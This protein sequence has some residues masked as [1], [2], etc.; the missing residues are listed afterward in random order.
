MLKISKKEKN[1]NLYNFDLENK[2]QKKIK[3]KD[4]REAINP[5]NSNNEIII[6]VTKYPDDKK[7]KEKNKQDKRRK[8]ANSKIKINKREREDKI[9]LK[10]EQKKKINKKVENAD[11]I[12]DNPKKDYT[13]PKKVI[14]WTSICAI[15]IGI[16]VYGML[17]P[18]FNINIVTVKNNEKIPTET[19][20]NLANIKIGENI[21][22]INKKEIEKNIKNNGYIDKI[23]VKRKLPDEI[24][25][26]VKERKATYMV[27][28]GNGYAYINN[29][30]YILE[31]SSEKKELPI[32]YGINTPNDNLVECERLNNEDLEKLNTVLK[33][34]NE[35]EVNNIESLITAIDIGNSNDYKLYFGTENKTAYIGDCSNLET[36]MLYVT[37]ILKNETGKGGDIFVNMNL[38]TE[39]A[40]F[41]EKV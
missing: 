20:K 5:I 36:R 29:Q 31:I 32:L 11:K 38:N 9:L 21:F 3:Q 2:K 13:K 40:F 26:I 25:L 14:K 7:T 15:F 16:I 30:G 10:N 12:K 23:E 39:N 18:M 37:S 34:M 27:E 33:I 41:R 17:S 28:Y 6:G 8:K 22:R 19:I 24:E 4:K 35:A 1:Q